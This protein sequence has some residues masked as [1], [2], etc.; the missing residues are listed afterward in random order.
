MPDIQLDA[1]TLAR[2]QKSQDPN[3]IAELCKRGGLVAGSLAT[4]GLGNVVVA[5]VEKPLTISQKLGGIDMDDRTT[6]DGNNLPP[7]QLEYRK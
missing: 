5:N 6:T 3:E 1:E 2:I 4:D 7:E